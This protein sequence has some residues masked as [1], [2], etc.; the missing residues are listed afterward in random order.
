MLHQTKS[1][2]GSDIGSEEGDVTGMPRKEKPRPKRR[3]G[4]TQVVHWKAGTT[5]IEIGGILCYQ[6]S[7]GSTVRLLP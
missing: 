2:I 3:P 6:E 4:E 1:L 5:G 7:S